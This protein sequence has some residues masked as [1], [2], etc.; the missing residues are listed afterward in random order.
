M[1]P[2]AGS[3]TVGAQEAAP[4]LPPANISSLGTLSTPIDEPMRLGQ[5]WGTGQAFLEQTPGTQSPPI[6]LQQERS[7][8]NIDGPELLVK[9]LPLPGGGGVLGLELTERPE[10]LVDWGPRASLGAQR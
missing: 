9:A 6:G 3:V 7:R 1:A 10:W 5:G 4:H 8:I 2:G